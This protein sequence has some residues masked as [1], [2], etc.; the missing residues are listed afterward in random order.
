M[1]ATA[2]LALF[3]AQWVRANRFTARPLGPD[4]RYVTHCSGFGSR[5]KLSVAIA[6]EASS[7]LLG[8]LV[9]DRR[10]CSFMA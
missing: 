9:P 7:T 4:F 2:I 1:A 6:W 10:H 3:I 8:M 5:R